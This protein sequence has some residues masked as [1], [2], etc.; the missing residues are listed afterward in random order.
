MVK[1]IGIFIYFYRIMRI[2]KIH[3]KNFRSLK[4]VNID[5]YDL[6][7]PISIIGE[8]N[9]GKSNIIKSILWGLW[10]KY[11]W[12][13]SIVESDFHNQNV[14]DGI[15]IDICLDDSW[16][17]KQILFKTSDNYRD[18][19]A[20][21]LNGQ[22][23]WKKQK[24]SVVN[25]LFYYDFN[26]VASLLKIKTDFSYTP[27][28]KIVKQ[29]KDKFKD[30]QELQEEMNRKIEEFINQEV[31][32]DQDYQSFKSK[33]WEQLK[34]N[35]KNH[36]DDFDFKHTIQDVDK[37]INWLSFFVKESAGKPLISVENFGSGFRSLLVFSIFEAISESGNWGNV[38]IFEEPETFLHEN[39][40]EYFFELLKKLA[41]N[42]QVI[43]TTHSKKFVDVFNVWS[44]IRLHNNE[45]TWCATKICQKNLSNEVIKNINEGVLVD[46]N[47]NIILNF[48]DTYWSYMKAI[49][50]NI[51]LIAFSE[52]ILIVE[53]P[54]DVLAYKTAFWKGL[55][56]KGYVS[57]SLG[58]LGLNIVCVHNKDLIWPLMYICQQLETKAFIVFDSDLPLDQEINLDDDYFNKEYKLRDPY[59]NLDQKWKQHYTKTVKL[60]S[61]AKKLWFNF[62]IN[63]PKIEEVLN[64]ER[65]DLEKLTYKNKSSIEIYNRIKDFEYA[66]IKEEYPK[67]ITPEL[68]SFIYWEEEIAT[69]D[70]SWLMNS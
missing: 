3:I 29:I 40:E 18:A 65:E 21:T 34:K 16:V 46:D 48:P 39:F 23:Y 62:Q 9:A 5:F 27:L 53:W 32:G 61:I 51:W 47:N 42:N 14:W 11:M 19:P 38:Y 35:L 57:E 49:E 2:K 50:P 60:V 30:N 13:D 41:V 67:F 24:D 26:Q 43:I 7:S 37:I 15:L 45:S 31:A 17:E 28:G 70:S 6:N 12:E 10:H 25:K 20:L 36:S 44:I 63:R 55:L 56:E 33:I 64:F 68:E 59:L 4:D 1:Y 69:E 22:Y 58:Y 52:K 54:H 66:K 8:N